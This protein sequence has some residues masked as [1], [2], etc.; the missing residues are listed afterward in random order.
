MI[1]LVDEGGA[2]FAIGALHLA[3]PSSVLTLLSN[4]GYSVEAVMGGRRRNVLDKNY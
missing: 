4:N 1:P 3:G 2:F